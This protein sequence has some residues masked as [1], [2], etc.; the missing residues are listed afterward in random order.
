MQRFCAFLRQHIMRELLQFRN[1]RVELIHLIFIIAM[2]SLDQNFKPIC[3][4]LVH[5]LYSAFLSLCVLFFIPSV[6]IKK[7]I[8]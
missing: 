5:G 1:N 2:F 4:K 7:P 6:F 3:L 8:L